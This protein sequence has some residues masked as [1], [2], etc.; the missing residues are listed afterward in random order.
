MIWR[1]LKNRERRTYVPQASKWETKNLTCASKQVSGTE[2]LAIKYKYIRVGVWD[3]KKKW[4]EVFHANTSNSKGKLFKW[5]YEYFSG[6]LLSLDFKPLWLHLSSQYCTYL[7]STYMYKYKLTFGGQV[8][9]LWGKL[10]NEICEFLFIKHRVKVMCC[11]LNQDVRLTV[12]YWTVFHVRN[13]V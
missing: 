6:Y 11:E 8:V 10:N 13:K 12:K 1:R 5:R 7:I 2:Q 9:N 3:W 4:S